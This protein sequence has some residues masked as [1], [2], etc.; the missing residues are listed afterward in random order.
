MELQPFARGVIWDT[1]DPDDCKPMRASTRDDAVG[2]KAT[3]NRE[4]V[5]AAAA[6]LDWPHKD[7]MGQVDEGGVE[8][9]SDCS[10]ASGSSLQVFINTHSLPLNESQSAN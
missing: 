7:L 1:R 9:R 4:A 5:R 3:I 8:A 6:E 2:G 10:E